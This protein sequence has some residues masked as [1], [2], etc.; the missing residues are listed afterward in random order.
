[1]TTPDDS[2]LARVRKLLAK[3]EDGGCTPAE[4]EA[5]T[6]KAAELMA[7]YGIDRALAEQRENRQEAPANRIIDIP[8]PWAD[9]RA[10]L[11]GGLTVAMRC[12]AVLL[13]AAS[14][15]RIHM[16]GYASD[17]ERVDMLYTSLLLQ[18]ANGLAHQ[19]VPFYY[20]G[21]GVRAWRR[22]WL[23]GYVTAVIERVRAAEAGAET[24]AKAAETAG[25]AGTALVLR[26]REV[27][28]QS[29]MAKAYPNRRSIRV[30][31]SG[32]GYRD[33]HA[34]GQRANLGGTGISDG[35]RGALT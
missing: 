11:L 12:Q 16:F 20:Q 19:P 26:S 1:M 24:E 30:T 14:G 28:V 4:A 22:S 31:Y 18:M 33:G 32:G 3:A 17:L 34:A 7:K 10:H 6:V 27:A 35:R 29:E 21:N 25:P 8:N 2:M 9:V 5:L 13:P 23:L 15:K